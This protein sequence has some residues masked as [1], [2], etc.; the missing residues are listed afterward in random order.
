MSDGE[1]ILGGGARLDHG[2]LVCLEPN[3]HMAGD[4]E[5]LLE[6]MSAKGTLYHYL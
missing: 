5:P 4:V 6:D 1:P 2:V 3:G